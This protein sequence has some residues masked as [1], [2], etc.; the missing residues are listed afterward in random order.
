MAWRGQ[1][2]ASPG[3]AVVHESVAEQLAECKMAVVAR[4]GAKSVSI[5]S[6]DVAIDRLYTPLPKKEREHSISGSSGSTTSI[7]ER[8]PKEG[9]GWAHNEEQCRRQPGT[10][11]AR[12]LSTP[13]ERSKELVGSPARSFDTMRAG[14]TRSTISGIPAH[15]SLRMPRDSLG[16]RAY[17]RGPKRNRSPRRESIRHAETSATPHINGQTLQRLKLQILASTAARSLLTL[18]TTP[19]ARKMALPRLSLAH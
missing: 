1:W 17:R 2:C 9:P 18:S 11:R 14:G 6:P 8:T 4:Y 12:S 7:E 19:S 15:C 3:Y 10:S 16:L 5:F 13:S